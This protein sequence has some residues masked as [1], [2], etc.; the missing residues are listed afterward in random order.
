MEINIKTNC[1]SMIVFNDDTSSTN[2]N[3]EAVFYVP[4]S[5][6]SIEFHV[7]NDSLSKTILV[8]S[9]NSFAYWLNLYP[10]IAWTG[11]LIDKNNPKRYSYSNFIYVDLADSSRG[12]SLNKVYSCKQGKFEFVTSLPYINSFFI[13]PSG[14]GDKASTGYIGLAIGADYYY[15][16]DRFL[17]LTIRGVL[18]NDAPLI[19]EFSRGPIEDFYSTDISITD[20]FRFNR[21]CVGY[22]LSF[23]KIGWRLNDINYDD[24]SLSEFKH[25]KHD[26]L[27]LVLP[28]YYQFGRTFYA[29]VV[30]RP[31]FLQFDSRPS[32][33][34]EHIISLDFGWRYPI[35][36]KNN[37][38]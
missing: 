26:A 13:K 28:M 10:S 33:K 19:L 3:N 9:R 22:G 27:G 24:I 30:F 1:S 36:K 15:H 35:N 5:R 11:F 4:R 14:E 17:N 32:F 37:G 38:R 6:E 34:Y 8:P 23:A 18:N 25:K 29:G 12:Y 31:S 2:Y 7:Y 16:D 20:N 21:F